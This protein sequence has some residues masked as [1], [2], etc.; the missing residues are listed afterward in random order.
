VLRRRSVMERQGSR[1]RPMQIATGTLCALAMAII[2]AGCGS[3]RLP[4]APIEG[5]VLFHGKPLE[6]GGVL[7][8][9]DNGPPAQGRIEPDGTFRLSTYREHDGAVLGKH[10][11]QIACY[12]AQRPAAKASS[13]IEPGLGRPLVPTK[14]LRTDTSGLAVEVK[15]RNDPLVFDLK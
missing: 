1:W 15:P 5:K 4:T 3:K 6:F 8:Q 9:P 2:A 13:R 11:V 10:R 12:E 7:L 14:Y